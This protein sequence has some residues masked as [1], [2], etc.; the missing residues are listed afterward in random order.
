MLL[1]LPEWPLD[2]SSHYLD[3]CIKIFT[4]ELENAQQ[5]RSPAALAV[6]SYLRGC[7]RLARGEYIE[8]LRD[9]YSIE[10]PNLF[11]QQYIETVVVP[12]LA[13]ERLVDLFLSEPFYTK[14]PE[15]K[16]V[17]MRSIS[18]SMSSIDL[19]DSGKLAVTASV[20]VTPDIKELE[21][22]II[23]DSLTYRQFSDHVHRLDIIIDKDTTEALFKAL[24]YWIDNSKTKTLKRD[25]T[26]TN[27]TNKSPELIKS[28]NKPGSAATM[29]T[30]QHTADMLKNL[31]QKNQGGTPLPTPKL[32]T[33]P[34]LYLPTTLFETFVDIWQQTKAEKLRMSNHLPEDRQKHESILKV[35]FFF[36][37]ITSSI[38]FN[39]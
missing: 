26:L 9:L 7:A 30:F 18:Q 5:E 37:S 16:K 1:R 14:C 3:S 38:K 8:G 4:E 17:R 20:P 35:K 29:F 12:R 24:S 32:P 34:N 11:P 36:L 19:D 28:S 23:E 2:L 25:N 10:N 21:W 39:V 13:E 31:P 6:Y 22:D 15:W 33:E 27:N